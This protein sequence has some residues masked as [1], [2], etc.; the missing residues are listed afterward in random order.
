M[1]KPAKKAVK[2][3]AAAA[4]AKPKKAAKPAG[5]SKAPASKGP[6]TAEKQRF[7]LYG[8]AG[9]TSTYTAALGLALMRHPFSYMH[10]SLRDGAHKQP[11]FL[12]K[13]R[14]GQ[15]PALRDGQTYFVQSAAI[16][17]HLADALEKYD[18]KTPNETN[19]IREWMFW[20]W[21]RLAV[22]VFRLRARNRGL[23]QFGEEVRNMYD[24]DARSAIVTLDHELVKSDWVTG[25]KPTIADISIYGVLRYAHEAN[26]DL[27]AYPRVM[28]WKKRFEELP[29]F[30]TPESLL[31]MESRLI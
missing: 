8:F 30:A 23:R 25:K 17:M 15:V 1:A 2:K 20:Q 22:P 21:D 9:S 6:S 31:P 3:S 7:T 24:S 4:K 28:A 19:R 5:K 14:F 13:N 12:V 18:G 27:N 29:G 11:D 16:L 10:V 26:I